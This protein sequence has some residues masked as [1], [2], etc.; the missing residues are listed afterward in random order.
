VSVTWL[1]LDFTARTL[2]LW[3]QTLGGTWVIGGE[4]CPGCE[5][6]IHVVKVSRDVAAS[7]LASGRLCLRCAAGT[8]MQDQQRK[9]TGK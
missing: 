8:G 5:R 2:G 3:A 6:Q 4:Q 9:G 1:R 7:G